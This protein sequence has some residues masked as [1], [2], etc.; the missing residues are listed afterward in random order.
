M[1][2]SSQSG[3]QNGRQNSNS[4]NS[5]NLKSKED[6]KFENSTYFALT[7]K[8]MEDEGIPQESLQYILDLETYYDAPEDFP[9]SL[10]EL[11][12]HIHEIRQLFIGR[13][14]NWRGN[15]PSLTVTILLQL[16]SQIVNTEVQN[17]QKEEEARNRWMF[18]HQRAMEEKLANGQSGADEDE[19]IKREMKKQIEERRRQAKAKRDAENAELDKLPPVNLDEIPEEGLKPVELYQITSQRRRAAAKKRKEARIE[20]DRKRREALEA[21]AEAEFSMYEAKIASNKN[22]QVES[23]S[24]SE[25]EIIDIDNIMDGVTDEKE[26]KE[27]QE[28][29]DEVKQTKMKANK[30]KK[31]RDLKKKEQVIEEASEEPEIVIEDEVIADEI[32]IEDEVIIEKEPTPEPPKKV[33]K[34]SKKVQ[35][36]KITI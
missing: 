29:I 18:A 25:I 17:L 21:Q 33:K 15:F 22:R 28:A 9:Q 13:R 4:N 30:A 3:N 31:K 11:R 2:S 24:E 5:N 19:E 7:L 23:D 36:N 8:R 26:R 1:S 16:L 27:L 14:K 20:S 34:K 32:V 35:S 10:V 12:N 6:S